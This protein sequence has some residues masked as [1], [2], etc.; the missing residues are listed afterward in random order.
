MSVKIKLW[1]TVYLKP[2]RAVI[3]ASVLVG[4]IVILNGNVLVTFGHTILIKN[5]TDILT[6]CY[7][8]NDPATFWMGTWNTVIKMNILLYFN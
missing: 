7:S 2:E 1:R 6:Q 3:V 8:T 5:D 4:T